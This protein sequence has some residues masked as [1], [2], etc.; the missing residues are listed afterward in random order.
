MKR[1]CPHGTDQRDWLEAEM[2]LKSET[3]GGRSTAMPSTQ[4]R[5]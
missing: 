3:M 2:E 1:G 4:Q 5:R